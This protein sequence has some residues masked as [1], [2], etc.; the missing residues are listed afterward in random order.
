MDLT[1]LKFKIREIK[2]LT[3][4][5]E[6][7]N[8]ND[9][10]KKLMNQPDFWNDTDNASKLSAELSDNQKQLDNLT[11]ITAR[12][13]DLQEYNDLLD[14][15]N[16]LNSEHGNDNTPDDISS[17]DTNNDDYLYLQNEYENAN[18][19]ADD[20]ITNITIN[21]IQ[22]HN[23][24]AL[25]TL[26]AGSGGTESENWCHMLSRMYM[27]WCELHDYETSID[28]ITYGDG[29][30]GYELV[31]S[32]TIRI[33][34]KQGHSYDSRNVNIYALLSL[35]AGRHK[36]IRISPFDKDKRRQTSLVAVDVIPILDDSIKGVKDIIIDPKDLRI[37]VFNA[38]GPG[39]QGVNTTYSA[40]RI[41]HI[42]TGIVVSQQDERDQHKNKDKAMMVLKTRLFLLKQ[43]EQQEKLR[44][45]GNNVSTG[46]GGTIRNYVLY[47]YQ[48]VKDART[49]FS[50]ENVN[51]LLNDYNDVSI[52]DGFI[53]SELSWNIMNQRE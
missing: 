36:L 13:N 3:N 43:K 34:R 31:R 30:A 37:D 9:Y 23:R 15:V 19:T 21:S 14:E 40:V 52:L 16:D 49:G 22:Y 42:P 10:I 26:K 32:V 46:M 28:D 29:G 5:K 44:K 41:T 4:V 48:L 24:G 8:R 39:G 38:S 27:N 18:S 17:T 53:D 12:F 33:T 11:E 47:P 20:M 25:L 2:K 50:S 1:E 35:E 51:G 7:T 45:L 6:L